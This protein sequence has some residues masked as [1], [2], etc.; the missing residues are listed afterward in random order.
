MDCRILS[1]VLLA[2]SV[3]AVF[4]ASRLLAS[5]PG[6][7]LPTKVTCESAN[8]GEHCEPEAAVQTVQAGFLGKSVEEQIRDMRDQLEKAQEAFKHASQAFVQVAC[9]PLSC[10]VEDDRLEHHVYQV[11]DLVQ[12]NAASGNRTTERELMDWITKTVRPETW[13]SAGGT[14]VMDYYPLGGSLVVLQRRSVQEEIQKALEARRP[15]D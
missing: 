7:P 8:T 11:S 9:N 4:T 12:P 10:F 1:R 13:K 3:F 5:P 2:L 14:G 15:K 6:L